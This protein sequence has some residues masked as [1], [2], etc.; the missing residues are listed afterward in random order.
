MYPRPHLLSSQFAGV[1]LVCLHFSPISHCPN[2]SLH[3][4]LFPYAPANLD[5][6]VCHDQTHSEEVNCW[7]EAASGEVAFVLDGVIA[8]HG[9]HVLRHVGRLVWRSIGLVGRWSRRGA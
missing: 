3:V 7:S 6:A 4:L 9:R 1:Q 5:E 2:I 8:A